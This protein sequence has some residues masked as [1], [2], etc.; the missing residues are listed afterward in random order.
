MPCASLQTDLCKLVPSIYLSIHPSDCLSV[1]PS[2][3]GLCGFEFE[4]TSPHFPDLGHLSSLGVHRVIPKP[5]KRYNRSSESWVAGPPT[6]RT[7]NHTKELSR[8]QCLSS[9]SYLSG[10]SQSPFEGNSFPSL[11]S[12]T[13]CHSVGHYLELMTTT[14]GKT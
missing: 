7:N 6:N 8:R 14:E 9:L 12:V 10:R 4:Q 2:F 3:N 5:A 1:C 11:V 13:I